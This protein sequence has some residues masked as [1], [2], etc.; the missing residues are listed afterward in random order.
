MDRKKVWV[1]IILL[2]GIGLAWYYFSHKKVP[3]APVS[4]ITDPESARFVLRNSDPK[5]KI[6]VGE[7]TQNGGIKQNLRLVSKDGTLM[8]KM[9]GAD[10]KTSSVSKDGQTTEFFDVRTDADL[11]YALEKDKISQTIRIKGKNAEASYSFVLDKA[12]KDV[13]TIPNQVKI[14]ADQSAWWQSSA[15]SVSVI[16]NQMIIKIDPKLIYGTDAK[17]PLLVKLELTY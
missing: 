13:V 12:G 7:K 6:Y 2:L 3:T 1:W 14:S 17:F 15:G 10:L 16:D 11:I 4:Q 5:L 9:I 8:L